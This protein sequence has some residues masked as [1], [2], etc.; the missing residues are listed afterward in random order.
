V[1]AIKCLL[2]AARVALW[3]RI[4]GMPDDDQLPVWFSLHNPWRLRPLA[5]RTSRGMTLRLTQP[6][7]EDLLEIFISGILEFGEATACRKRQREV[8]KAAGSLAKSRARSP[9]C[10]F[11][12]PNGGAA[13]P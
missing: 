2:C 7:E 13:R 4:A 10:G 6:A 3:E 8:T 5:Q 12:P 1:I 11:T 9:V